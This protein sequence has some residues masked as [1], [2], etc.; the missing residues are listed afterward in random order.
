MLP[1]QI[2]YYY[3]DGKRLSSDQIKDNSESEQRDDYDGIQPANTATNQSSEHDRIPRRM[4]TN[5][6][7]GMASENKQDTLK[8]PNLIGPRVDAY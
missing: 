3:F 1:Y 7:Q 6:E 2:D 4:D 8:R 5:E